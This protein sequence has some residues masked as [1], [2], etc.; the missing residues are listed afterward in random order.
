MEISVK[1]NSVA[2]LCH[3]MSDYV[4]MEHTRTNALSMII[5]NNN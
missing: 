3:I 2:E 5:Q 4:I 1:K